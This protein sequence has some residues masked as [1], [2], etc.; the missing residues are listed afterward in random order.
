MRANAWLKVALAVI[1]T[2]S[3]QEVSKVGG[4]ISFHRTDSHVLSSDAAL[5]GVNEA[6]K[7]RSDPS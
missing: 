3:S 4:C 5:D 1:G 2:F 7:V 6:L